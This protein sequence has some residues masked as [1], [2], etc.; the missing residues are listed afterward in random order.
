MSKRP[1]CQ[2]TG[3]SIHY[4]NALTITDPLSAKSKQ[5]RCLKKYLEDMIGRS[6]KPLFARVRLI[7]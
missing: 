3:N 2:T 7:S 1:F 5:Y 6:I 4:P